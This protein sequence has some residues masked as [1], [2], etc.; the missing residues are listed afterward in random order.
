MAYAHD[1]AFLKEYKAG[2]LLSARELAWQHDPTLTEDQVHR[3]SLHLFGM[4]QSM[5]CKAVSVQCFFIQPSKKQDGF[6]TYNDILEWYLKGA[7]T[8]MYINW[9]KVSLN[10]AYSDHSSEGVINFLEKIQGAYANYD[11]AIQQYGNGQFQIDLYK[12][13][14]IHITSLFQHSDENK[15]VYEECHNA[16]RQGKSFNNYICDLH[17]LYSYTTNAKAAKAQCHACKAKTNVM[18]SFPDLCRPTL[19]NGMNYIFQTRPY[20][21]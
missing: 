8:N 10:V 1:E 20:S 13:C 4:L 2:G 21:F 19:V 12:E 14:I 18:N 11:H 3:D 15:M 5:C 7:D 6:I 9:L 16:I 17:N